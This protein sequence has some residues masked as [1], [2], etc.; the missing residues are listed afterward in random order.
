MS[1]RVGPRR[2]P[3]RTSQALS[4]FSSASSSARSALRCFRSAS[5]ALRSSVRALLPFPNVVS[6]SFSSASPGRRR[7]RL[8]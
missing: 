5:S 3:A 1:T 4:S 2:R 6:S 7:V 8:R